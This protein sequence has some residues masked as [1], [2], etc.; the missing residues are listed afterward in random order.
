MR[1]VL[2]STLLGRKK[3]AGRRVRE[4]VANVFRHRYIEAVQSG[5]DTGQA[6]IHF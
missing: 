3:Q 2:D 4:F 1:W 6:D 5:F